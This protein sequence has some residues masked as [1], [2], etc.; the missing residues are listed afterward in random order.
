MNLQFRNILVG[1][2][3]AMCLGTPAGAAQWIPSWAAAP[4]ASVPPPVIGPLPFALNYQTVPQV[5]HLSVGG[6]RLRIR[7][8]NEYGSKPL[9]VGAATIARVSAAGSVDRSSLR[10]LTFSGL[11]SAVI[12]ASAPLL[13]DP[14]DLPARGIKVIGA[15]IAPY[16]GAMYWS[17]EGESQRKAINDWIRHGGALDAVGDFD[18]AFRD[19]GKPTRM[20]EGK[21]MGDY[22]HGNDAGYDAVGN[23]IGLKLFRQLRGAL[24][25]ELPGRPPTIPLMSMVCPILRV[26]ALS[27][28]APQMEH[29]TIPLIIAL[30]Q[31]YC[32]G[33][34]RSLSTSL[35]K[36]IVTTG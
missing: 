26:C 14:I 2:M 33:E 21:Q 17:A 31:P 3:V 27:G 7:L 8:T 25:R 34:I 32:R 30:I 15:T 6:H 12:P 29:R 36:I 5:L 16:E 24:I 23:S 10:K 9:A 19:P 13:S 11:A 1:S 20:A 4:K 28:A 18:A 35:A 22:L